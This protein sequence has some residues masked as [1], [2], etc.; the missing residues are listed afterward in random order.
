LRSLVPLDYPMWTVFGLLTASYPPGCAQAS[1]FVLG[2]LEGI[3]RPWKEVPIADVR[4]RVDIIDSRYI[5]YGGGVSS[6]ASPQQPIRYMAF[7]AWRTVKWDYNDTAPVCR[8]SWAPPKAAGVAQRVRC[9]QPACLLS[10]ENLTCIV[11]MKTVLCS[12]HA[13]APCPR[14]M[15]VNPSET[16]P[17]PSAGA[18]PAPPV[19]S[20]FSL[21]SAWRCYFV[22][23]TS[24]AYVVI[25]PAPSPPTTN[26]V[27]P[28]RMGPDCVLAP[29]AHEDV[30]DSPMTSTVVKLVAGQILLVPG[31]VSGGVVVQRDEAACAVLFMWD[32]L[33]P[34]A[35]PLPPDRLKDLKIIR[36][37]SSK[38]KKKV[39]GWWCPCTQ[40]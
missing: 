27:Y 7:C 3:P 31:G 39:T 11:C 16:Q 25:T 22:T 37:A 10:P 5:H 29:W 33:P 40:V 24:V 20:P 38:G 14:C 12:V 34:G 23:G 32:V 19:E 18:P 30:V 28:Q 4:G 21:P 1:R 17:A 6:T 2:S 15:V 35:V 9:G 13:K 36:P 26:V 8:P